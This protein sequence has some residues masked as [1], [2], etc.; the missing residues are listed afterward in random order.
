MTA[1]LATEVRRFFARRLVRALAILAVLGMIVAAVAVFVTSTSAEEDLATVFHFTDMKEALVGVSPLLAI[2][3]LILGASFVGAEWQAGT[4]TTLLT[5]EPRRVRVLA[6]K[7]VAAL[8]GV[9]LTV[10]VLQILLL[11]IMLPVAAI[12][13][14]T[15]GIDAQWLREA[16]ETMGRVAFAGGLCAIIA[17]AIATIGRTTAAALGVAFAY[18]AIVESLLR[19]FKPHWQ[20]WFVGD[21]LITLIVADPVQASPTGHT[22]AEAGVVVALY[23]GLLFAAALAFFRQRDIS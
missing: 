10:V 20:P 2:V 3:G 4:F 17:F 11:L 7:A 1:L 12:K 21:N 18:F 19:G 5:W 15:D 9:M 16:A 23:A 6:A 22:A 14:S 13:G 8:V